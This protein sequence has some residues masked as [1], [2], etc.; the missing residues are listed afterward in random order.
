MASFDKIFKLAKKT[1]DRLI[2]FDSA[3]G[4]GFA[5]IPIDE[6]EK[7]VGDPRNVGS[8]SGDELIEQIN[9]DIGLWREQKE[10]DDDSFDM[11]RMGGDDMFGPST[12]WQ[13]AGDVL[14]NRFRFDEDFDDDDDD[15]DEDWYDG[16]YVGRDEYG[17][18]EDEDEDFWVEPREQRENRG[19]TPFDFLNDENDEEDSYPDIRFDFER[20]EEPPF[21]DPVPEFFEEE[22]HR[23]IPPRVVPPEDVWEEEPLDEDPIFFEEPV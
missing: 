1:G 3:T 13:S 20:E 12:D 14:Q 23:P 21:V 11:P 10:H 18:G 16:Y 19:D 9:N 15:E 5:A 17:L 8:L 22:G 2:V 6:Y 7:M 4:D